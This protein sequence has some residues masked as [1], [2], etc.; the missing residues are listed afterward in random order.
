MQ[1]FFLVF[2]GGGAG[3][4]CRFLLSRSLNEHHFLAGTLISNI[5]AS[6]ILGYL[7][8]KTNL[9]DMP[10]ILLATGFCG[11]FSTFSTFSLES[12]KL[13]QNGSVGQAVL[14]LSANFLVC[15]FAIL[16]GYLLQK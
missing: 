12:F 11:G 7:A 8:F 13:L 16:A 15:L 10:K 4:I 5:L 9:N 1:Q 3:S 6:F 2:I 14:H